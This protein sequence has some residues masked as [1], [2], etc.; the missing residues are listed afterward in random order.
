MPEIGPAEKFTRTMEAC[1][2]FMIPDALPGVRTAV[3]TALTC[4]LIDE[5]HKASIDIAI[6]RRIAA[7]RGEAVPRG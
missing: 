6:E 4:G 7:L 5:Q 2:F 1:V 3:L